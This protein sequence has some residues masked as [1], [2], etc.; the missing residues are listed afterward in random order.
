MTNKPMHCW[1]FCC[2]HLLSRAAHFGCQQ[3]SIKEVGPGVWFLSSTPSRGWHA[4]L[5]SLPAG[6]H[7]QPGLWV[8]LSGL[9]TRPLCSKKTKASQALMNSF[10]CF[11]GFVLL[12][13]EYQMGGVY[14]IKAA[15]LCMLVEKLYK[16]GHW[17][18]NSA[19]II[20]YQTLL[21]SKSKPSRF[22]F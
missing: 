13:F 4:L 6:L 16:R 8:D 9:V 18:T 2:T 14:H 20:S 19:F 3:E 22:Y 10:P 11:V 12:C 1:H 7:Q 15:V 5:Y 17:L 21:K